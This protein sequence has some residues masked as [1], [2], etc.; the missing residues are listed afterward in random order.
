MPAAEFAEW[1]AFDRVEP[2][3]V[4]R[5]DY[6]AALIAQAV[7]NTFKSKGRGLSLGKFLPDWWKEAER[8]ARG[9]SAFHRFGGMVQQA[10][11]HLTRSRGG[12]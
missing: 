7:V 9:P 2:I 8:P 5:G 10:G 3:G 11:R 12:S 1:R 4:R 6:Q